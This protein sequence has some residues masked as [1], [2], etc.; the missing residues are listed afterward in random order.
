VPTAA[1]VRGRRIQASARQAKAAPAAEEAA[2]V[3]HITS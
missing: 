3:S 2:A 1:A